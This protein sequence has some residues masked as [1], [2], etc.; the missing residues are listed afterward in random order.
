MS[1][2]ARSFVDGPGGRIT[3]GIVL[4]LVAAALA[5]Y[6]R[7]DLFGS[8]QVTSTGNPALDAC[9]AERLGQVERMVADGVVEGAQ[10]EA[11]RSR[12]AELCRQTTGGE[13]GGAPGLPGV[14]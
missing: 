14:Q 7:E 3:A 11:F 4:V 10:A 2:P 6:H 8:E 1:A 12:A 5:F 9:L 13:D